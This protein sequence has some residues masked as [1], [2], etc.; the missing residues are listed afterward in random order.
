MCVQQKLYTV[1]PP[2]LL[3]I[4]AETESTQQS[5][6]TAEAS[7]VDAVAT[8]NGRLNG[9]GGV[10][11]NGE[12]DEETPVA[13]SS[14]TLAAMEKRLQG[15]IDH[16]FAE[17]QRQIDERFEQLLGRVLQQVAMVN[18]RRD[19]RGSENAIYTDQDLPT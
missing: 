8:M 9:T 6:S 12:V 2:C 3:H 16:K 15:Y 5:S 17:I 4:T 11:E 10:K 13:H 7:G 1:I 18:G 19:S 14:Q